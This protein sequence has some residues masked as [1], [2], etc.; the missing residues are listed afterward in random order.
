MS[1]PCQSNQLVLWKWLT[2]SYPLCLGIQNSLIPS[3]LLSES[4]YAFLILCHTIFLQFIIQIQNMLNFYNTYNIHKEGTTWI[5]KIKRILSRNILFLWSC[6]SRDEDKNNLSSVN[7]HKTLTM[8]SLRAGNTLT[9]CSTILGTL[10]A[11]ERRILCNLANSFLTK[12]L[13]GLGMKWL[14]TILLVWLESPVCQHPN[15]NLLKSER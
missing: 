9:L 15:S 4:F 8:V 7:K 3:G 14:M 13:F 2:L 1:I 11:K 6:K 5:M 12:D 10:V